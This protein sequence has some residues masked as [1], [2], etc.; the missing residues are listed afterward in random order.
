LR[1]VGKELAI[2][3]AKRQATL[4]LSAR[5]REELEV[6]K[7]VVRFRVGVQSSE[8][9]SINFGLVSWLPRVAATLVLKM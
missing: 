8:F 5:R 1:A 9:D 6:R 7:P 2:E 3:M 4:V